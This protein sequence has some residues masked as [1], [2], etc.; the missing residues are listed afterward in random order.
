MDYSTLNVTNKTSTTTTGSSSA[1][2][3]PNAADTQDR[4][5]KLLVAQ[6]Q[7]QDP[8]NPMDNAQVTTQLAQI[9]TVTGVGNVNTSIQSLATQ[10]SQM[11]ALQSVSL[12]GRSVTVPGNAVTV[13]NGKAELNYELAN[14]ADSVKLEILNGGGTVISTQELGAQKAGSR[15]FTWDASK[16]GETTGLTYRITATSNSNPVT[17]TTY[18][19]DVVSA[20]NTGGST[21]QLELKNNGLVDYDKVRAIV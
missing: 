15:N 9:Q 20:V 21:L 18:T 3:T 5:L 13:E 19:R 6:M 12:V 8:M 10:F 11:Q 7:N 4:F 14:P 1:S 16:A 2:A 17:A